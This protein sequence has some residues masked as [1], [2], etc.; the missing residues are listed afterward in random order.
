MERL[1]KK[2]KQ[3]KNLPLYYPNKTSEA[4]ILDYSETEILKYFHCINENKVYTLEEMERQEKDLKLVKEL[5]IFKKIILV[6]SQVKGIV[7]DKGYN[8]NLAN[9]KLE[10]VSFNDLVIVMQNIGHVLHTLQCYREQE[11]IL[12]TFFIGDLHEGNILVNSKTKNIQICDIDSCKIGSNKP[13]P[14]K[15][16]QFYNTYNY[17]CKK[18]QNKY[19]MQNDRAIP[20]SNTDLYCYI[21]MILDILFNFNIEYLNILD[22]HKVIYSLREQ[23]LPEPLYQAFINLY[24]PLDNINPYQYL[25]AIPFSF[26]RKL[27]L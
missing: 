19:P 23:G 20:N 18:L 13:F 5:L 6:N 22:Y 9:F 26:E 24:H 14:T 27:T 25:D 4:T 1:Y 8:N 21:K 2:E 16:L 15:Y 17:V 12:K 7:L 11:G 3:L 10:N